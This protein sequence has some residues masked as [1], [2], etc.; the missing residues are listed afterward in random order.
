MLLAR[1]F[2]DVVRGMT[3]SFIMLL[4][5]LTVFGFRFHGTLAE[6]VAAVF[7]AVPL[8]F[9]MNWFFIWIGVLVKKPETTQIAG[10]LV[11]FPLM[12][13]SSAYVP[14]AS[15]P[16]WLQALAKVNPLSYTV[17][18]ARG[19]SLGNPS[20]GALGKSILI[21]TVLAA[22]SILGATTAYRRI[23]H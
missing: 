19:L 9:A 5:G 15:L 3:Q 12:F 22:V 6:S 11:T 18:A 7:V 1:N 14:V 2:S 10:M 4:L 20:S 16:G 17:D 8:S 13:A 23:D 21:A